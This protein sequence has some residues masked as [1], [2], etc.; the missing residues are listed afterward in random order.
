M[1][2]PIRVQNLCPASR[3]VMGQHTRRRSRVPGVGRAKEANRKA[4]PP[5]GQMSTF[6]TKR[7]KI[8][9]ALPLSRRPSSSAFAIVPAPLVMAKSPKVSCSHGAY[10]RPRTGIDQ[11]RCQVISS[12]RSPRAPSIIVNPCSLVSSARDVAD[13]KCV[14]GCPAKVV[15][16]RIAGRVLGHPKTDRTRAVIH[17]ADSN[18][19]GASPG[20]YN[21]SASGPSVQRPP[22]PA[23]PGLG[24]SLMRRTV[25]DAMREAAGASS[26]Q[27]GAQSR[28][29]RC[30]TPGTNGAGAGNPTPMRSGPRQITPRHRGPASLPRLDL[31]RN[32]AAFPPPTPKGSGP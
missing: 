6:S 18:D 2:V 10:P 17:P 11:A 29:Q 12:S 24:G 4:P 15:G 32:G 30:P 27:C 21:A 13:K 14:H 23:E 7:P 28:A 3:T 25:L 26:G 1:R 22:G 8:Y 20:P 31:A 16:G 19:G 5:A 9:P